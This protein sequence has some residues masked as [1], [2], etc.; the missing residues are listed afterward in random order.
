MNE[1]VKK[2]LLTVV[3]VGIILSIVV[4]LFAG[5]MM[6]KPKESDLPGTMSN[7]EKRDMLKYLNC[8]YAQQ[9]NKTIDLKCNELQN[10]MSKNSM[11]IDY[12]EL[13]TAKKLPKLYNQKGESEMTFDDYFKFV[14]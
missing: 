6:S 4:M 14:K 5:C 13:N 1:E 9:F 7:M 11:I 8:M 3:T 12:F 10:Q 2:I